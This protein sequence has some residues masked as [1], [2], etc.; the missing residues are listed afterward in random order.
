MLLLGG[1]KKRGVK[2]TVVSSNLINSYISP[3]ISKMLSPIVS[4]TL[5]LWLTTKKEHFNEEVVLLLYCFSLR[6][7]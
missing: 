4:H 7:N 1:S 6:N 5:S 2:K 3:L